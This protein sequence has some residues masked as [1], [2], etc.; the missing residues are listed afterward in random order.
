VYGALFRV[1]EAQ[2]FHRAVAGIALPNDASIALH[3]AVGFSEVGV[4]REVGRKFGRWHDVAW[5][6]RGLAF[7]ASEAQEPIP[8]PQ[9]DPALVARALR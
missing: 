1:L 8:L 3:R 4:Y 6:E 9:L 7:T 5:Y 2:G